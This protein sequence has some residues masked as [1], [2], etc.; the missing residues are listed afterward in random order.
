MNT[1][2]NISYAQYL[3]AP[4]DDKFNYSMSTLFPTNRTPSFWVNW[5]NVVKNMQEH[6]IN[7]NTL[8]YLVGKPDIETKA[9][10]LFREQP[11]LL[12]TVPILL[13]CRDK[14]LA[15]LDISSTGKLG[16]Y[17]LNFKEPDLNKLDKYI[18]FLRESGLFVF[19]QS[20]LN[21]SLVDYVYGIQAGLDSNG[22]KNRGGTQN[23]DVL[24]INLK[25]LVA[26]FSNLEYTTQATRDHIEK[27][28]HISVPEALDKSKKGGRRYDGA[29]YNQNTGCITVIETNFY[30]SSGSKLK[31]VCG[32]FSEMYSSYLKSAS[33]V[34]FVW[35]TDGPGWNQAKNPLHEAFTIIPKIINLNMINAGFLEKAII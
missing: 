4:V 23:E 32:E 18:T 6:E 10:K 1:L 33:N 34:N 17:N 8:N 5:D 20:N 21:K 19:L 15:V 27:S 12:K 31:S 11:Q 29:V 13:A 28:W 24:E 22:R 7:L 30:V 9:I 3:N 25:N 14:E 26:K 2:G 16:T 35:I